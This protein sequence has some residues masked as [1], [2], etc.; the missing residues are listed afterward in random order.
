MRKVVIEV[1]RRY[2]TAEG[3]DSVETL[4]V[5]QVLRSDS[6]H[7][8]GV[9]RIKPRARNG[10][11]GLVGALGITRIE[12]LSEEKDGSFIAYMEGV[13]MSHWI[14][15]GSSREAYQSPPFELTP[16][17]WRK[18]L[19]GSGTQIRR[20]LRRFE[21]AGLKFKIVWSGEAKFGP[22]ALLSA[23]TQGQ[24]KTLSVAHDVGY[25]D[26]PRRVGSAELSKALGLSKSTV[27]EHLRRAEKSV[28]DQV[29][30]S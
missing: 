13:P 5:I 8:S 27:S 3:A 20:S 12:P 30:N 21:E 16:T 7:Y 23:L 29:L 4:S 25:F 10:L 19:V 18:T 24:R 15:S 17:S 2:L 11:K 28:F 14:R 9:A 22:S 6:D 1:P 26:F